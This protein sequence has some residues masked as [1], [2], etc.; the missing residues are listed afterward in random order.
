MKQSLI[1]C[2]TKA[3]VLQEL[4]CQFHYFKHL[5]I[6]LK[7]KAS[8]CI[9]QMSVLS[10]QIAPQKIKWR[11]FVLKNNPAQLTDF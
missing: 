10:E 6:G 2:I 3:E 8:T 9:K 1:L 11:T 5:Y 4:V 7:P